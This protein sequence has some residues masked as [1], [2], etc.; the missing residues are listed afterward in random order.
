MLL[1]SSSRLSLDDRALTAHGSPIRVAPLSRA[2][3]ESSL[4]EH[5]VLLPESACTSPFVIVHDTR[6]TAL[7]I[8]PTTSTSPGTQIVSLDLDLA[9]I[10]ADS[11]AKSLLFSP[12]ANKAAFYT[13]G[14]RVAVPSLGADL[15]VQETYPLGENG[16]WDVGVAGGTKV[17]EPEPEAKPEPVEPA[18]SPTKVAPPPIQTSRPTVQ[19]LDIPLSPETPAEARI[20]VTPA[21]APAL[22]TVAETEAEPE[23]AVTPR[24][25]TG[26]APFS[27]AEKK[28]VLSLLKGVAAAVLYYITRSAWSIF[29]WGFRM[30]GVGVRAANQTPPKSPEEAAEEAAALVGGPSPVAKPTASAPAPATTDESESDSETGS[31]NEVAPTPIDPTHSAHVGVVGSNVSSP[32]RKPNLNMPLTPPMSPKTATTAPFVIPGPVSPPKPKVTFTSP[33]KSTVFVVGP[34]TD[35]LEVKV[36]GVRIPTA[37]DRASGPGEGC[38]W[39]MDVEV[40]ENR[41]EVVVA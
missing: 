32:A 13:P 27:H 14:A 21:K 26:S 31:L 9:K 1:S 12:S 38:T 20:E 17:N 24:S 6:G 35:E 8:L 11:P 19:E 22:E 41:I 10:A 28:G 37:W 18:A 16:L 23:R 3:V 15:L 25:P 39:V 33:S 40:G 34:S 29:G 2:A 7:S 4:P 5:A 36:G 30:F